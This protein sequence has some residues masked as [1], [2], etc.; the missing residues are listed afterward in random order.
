MSTRDDGGPAFPQPFIYD[1]ERGMAG[2]FVSTADATGEVGLSKRDFF[3]AHA[4]AGMVA[5]GEHNGPYA[6]ECAYRYADAM[7]AARKEQP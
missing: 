7:L 3:A 2:D 1:A 6:A 5:R 4:L